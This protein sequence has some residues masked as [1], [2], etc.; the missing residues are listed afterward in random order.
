MIADEFVEKFTRPGGLIERLKTYLNF[1]LDNF[2]KESKRYKYERCNHEYAPYYI[3][4]HNEKVIGFYQPGIVQLNHQKIYFQLKVK[5]LDN[6]DK[7]SKRYKYERCK[8]LYF[9]YM[10]EHIYFL[11]TNVLMLLSKPSFSFL[12][13]FLEARCNRNFFEYY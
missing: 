10:L 3:Y 12:Q 1:D 5:D 4:F 6:F 13:S 9:F 7:E 2:D 11:K 8:I